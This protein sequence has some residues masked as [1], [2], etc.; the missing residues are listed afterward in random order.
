ML[1][2]ALALML[3]ACGATTAQSFGSYVPGQHVYDRAGVL[4]S[5]QVADLEARAAAVQRAGAPVVVYLRLRDATFDETLQDAQDL[6]NAWDLQSTTG[7]HD[8]V[9]IFLNLKPSDNRHGEAALYAGQKWVDGGQLAQSEQ[10]R[11]FDQVMQ[12]RLAAGD[13]AGGIAAGLDAVQHDLVYGPPPAPA[14]SEAQQVTAFLV[15]IPLLAFSLLL[16]LLVAVFA[17]RARRPRPPVVPNADTKTLDELA[18]ALVGALVAGRVADNQMVATLLDFARRGILAI[19]PAGRRKAQVRL[20][21]RAPQV[22]SFEDEV[23]RSIAD[24]ADAD[25]LVVANDLP[26]LRSRWPSAKNALR[27]ELVSRGWYDPGAGA[28]RGPIYIVATVALALSVAAFVAASVDQAP[29]GFLTS[30]LLFAVAIVAYFVGYRVSDTSAAGE[31]AAAPWRAYLEG[32]KRAGRDAAPGGDLAALLDAAVP[33]ALAAGM[34]S[35]LGGQLKEARQ[36]GYAPTWMGLQRATAT[37]EDYYPVWAAFVAAT[38]PTG[39]GASG[40]ASAGGAG[41]GGGF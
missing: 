17:L 20:L 39:G 41:A 22:A 15:G 32:A 19:E 29:I 25:G 13:T 10:Q 3:S 38:T 35:A 8:G 31:Q 5:P 30:G 14:P 36:Q 2:L 12:P 16:A 21:D 28:R 27:A 4:T 24:V 11:I 7:A 6:M 40:A 18:P 9:V 33:Y 23:Y 34:I 37:Y 26:K 1:M